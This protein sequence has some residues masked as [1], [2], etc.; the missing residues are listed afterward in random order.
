MA[1]S[2]AEV[3]GLYR[4]GLSVCQIMQL[5]GLRAAPDATIRKGGISGG[6]QWCL[7]HRRHEELKAA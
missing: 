1:L 4:S 3:A 6:L 5:H 7:I 2:P